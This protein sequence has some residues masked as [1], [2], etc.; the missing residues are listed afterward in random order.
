MISLFTL[1]SKSDFDEV[2]GPDR[3]GIPPSPFFGLCGALPPVD[4][5]AFCFVLDADSP[6]PER[7]FRVVVT[8]EPR[9]YRA[10]KEVNP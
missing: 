7:V 1:S 5:H 2:N 3:T 9:R 10:E 4:I 6:R 8:P